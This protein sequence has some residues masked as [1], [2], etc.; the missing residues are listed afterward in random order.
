MKK[1]LLAASIFLLLAAASCGREA[2]EG[3]NNEY[4]H[5][6]IHAPQ[7]EYEPPQ[8]APP[9]EYEPQESPPAE[10]T[11]L[12]LPQ[13]SVPMDV[14]ER[15]FS[16]AQALFDEDGGALWGFP[17]HVPIIIAD[18]TTRHAAANRPDPEGFFA[19]YGGVD[20][21]VLPED[22]SL[23]AVVTVI[24][25][26]GGERWVVVPLDTVMRSSL[27]ERRRHIAHYAMHWHQHCPDFFGGVIGFANTHMN[28]K[29]A[30]ISIRL[31]INAL[32]GA[33]RATGEARR[34]TVIDALSI[35]AARRQQ[36]DSAVDE[37]RLETLE[38]LAQFTE[39]AMTTTSQAQLLGLMEGFTNSVRYAGLE[40][41]FGY[42]SG[43]MYAFL[44]KET[45][46]AWTENL[47]IDTDLGQL[48]K[49]AMGID[50]LRPL[51]EVNLTRYGYTEIAAEEY[52][53]AATQAALLAQIT[54]LFID[55]PTLQLHE[56]DIG[57]TRASISGHFFTVAIPN[58]NSIWQGDI[59]IVGSFG[60]L[61]VRN[62]HV[63]SHG[64]LYDRF[65]MVTAQG[66][67]V[68]GSRIS[69]N[70]WTM[71]LNEGYMLLPDGDNFRIVREL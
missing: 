9:Q 5:E 45:D 23:F 32:I 27:A 24:H 38:G 13:F 55:N 64:F 28:E 41:M 36:F 12:I 25:D 22:F 39:W 3:N 33:F 19:C 35:R 4:I 60:Q 42:L 63:V 54:T 10:Y 30:R 59:E 51:N 44:L 21:G 16:Q 26:F 8:E 43:A 7:Q 67:E 52:V 53:W 11:P 34:N 29:Q 69:G 2:Q 40:R 56:E 47:T 31:E 46:K 20:F 61:N 18:P 58:F 70:T 49:E 6:Y 68:D 71:T 65:L 17:F 66:L 57:E 14:A 15:Y 50:E 62:G 37:N 48:L 1:L